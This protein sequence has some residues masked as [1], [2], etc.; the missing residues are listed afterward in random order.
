MYKTSLTVFGFGEYGAVL[1]ASLQHHARPEQIRTALQLHAG[2]SAELGHT[3]R[4]TNNFHCRPVALPFVPT[5]YPHA[6]SLGRL[7]SI[8]G[9]R[10]VAQGKCKPSKCSFSTFFFFFFLHKHVGVL[11]W[12]WES[13]H[14]PASVPPGP[15]GA[16]GAHDWACRPSLSAATAPEWTY[17]QDG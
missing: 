16:H 7:K 6:H 8:P 14:D 12:L 11:T 1:R 2:S 15:A 13:L 5:L 17:T 4:G 9:D 3:V 10:D